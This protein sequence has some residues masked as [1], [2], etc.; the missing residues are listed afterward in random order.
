MDTR[1][2]IPKHDMYAPAIFQNN[3]SSPILQILS[4]NNNKEE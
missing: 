2:E 3:A 4:V 1:E